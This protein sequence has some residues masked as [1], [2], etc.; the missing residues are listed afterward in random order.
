MALQQANSRGC[1][2]CGLENPVGLHLV[3]YEAH[4]GEVFADVVLTS[5]YEGFPGMAHGGVV[6]AML[7]EACGRALMGSDPQNPRFMYTARLEVRY[8][9]HV[10]LNQPLRLIGKALKDRGRVATATA[11]LQTVEGKVLAEAE[12]LLVDVPEGDYQG[13]DLESF[14]WKVYQEVHK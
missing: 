1:F 5:N 6:A 8:R 14:G 9:Q 2:I 12:A 3:F 7:D 4:A 10:P 11:S 13:V